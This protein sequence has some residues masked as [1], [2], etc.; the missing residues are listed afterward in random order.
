MNSGI[1]VTENQIEAKLIPPR[2]PARPRRSQTSLNS[3][4]TWTFPRPQRRRCFHSASTSR[5]SS[6]QTIAL[7]SN[8]TRLPSS[9]IRNVV[10]VSSARVV[11]SIRPPMPSS[12]SRVISCEP[13]ARHACAPRTFCA[14]RAAACAVMYSK[15]M[16]RF[17]YDEG[18]LPSLM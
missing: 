3:R 11:V 12:A 2:R 18:S 16:N 5:G 15:A 7:G 4:V 13:P 9:W 17:R 1:S 8:T 6:A 10:T 14:R